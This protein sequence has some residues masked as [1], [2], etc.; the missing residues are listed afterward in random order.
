MCPR[1]AKSDA[2]WGGSGN[3]YSLTAYN[4]RRAS[5]RQTQRASAENKV[6][7]IIPDERHWIVAD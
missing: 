2:E 5:C 1:A 7:W 6:E 4:Y 3:G